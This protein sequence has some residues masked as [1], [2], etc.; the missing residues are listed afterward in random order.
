MIST[1]DWGMDAA[2]KLSMY[3]NSL[4]NRAHKIPTYTLCSILS[5]QNCII[6]MRNQ[7][8]GLQNHHQSGVLSNSFFRLTSEKTP[9]ISPSLALHEG[10]RRWPFGSLYKGSV[11]WEVL[12][13]YDVI[14]RIEGKCNRLPVF[15]LVWVR[16]ERTVPRPYNCGENRFTTLK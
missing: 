16:H 9:S 4:R 14:S 13:C 7:G 11:L 10:N 3:L 15:N 5:I 2:E 8:C 6:V 12:P 1:F